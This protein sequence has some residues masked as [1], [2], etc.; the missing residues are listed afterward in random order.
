MSDQIIIPGFADLW[1][2]KVP[3]FALGEEANLYELCMVYTYRHPA[4]GGFPKDDYNDPTEEG[5]NCRL[6]L[7]G[8]TENGFRENPADLEPG[9]E[10][11]ADIAPHILLLPRT[12]VAWVGLDVNAKSL[13]GQIARLPIFP[14]TPDPA[15]TS[16]EVYQE[17]VRNIKD[18]A[19]VAKPIHL[20]DKPLVID[21]T[22]WRI[23]DP[24]SKLRSLAHERGDAAAPLLDLLA[25]RPTDE[26]PSE[27]SDVVATLANWIF[28][29]HLERLSFKELKK[30]ALQKAAH[31]G[32][33]TIKQFQTAYRRV[34]A[35]QK[36][37]PPSTGWPLKEPY[38][39]DWEKQS[40]KSF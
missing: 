31:F 26:A 40:E 23:K 5:M 20:H 22:L 30:C 12:P 1:G 25:K 3:P 8:A 13:P 36:H 11:C 2:N 33:F 4:C 6:L 7:L 10:C 16:N 27:A 35:T 17:L 34:Y 15:W 14:I 37:A 19:I 29:Q 32:Q 38:K 18:S 39:T 24:T 9:P 28:E 21:Y